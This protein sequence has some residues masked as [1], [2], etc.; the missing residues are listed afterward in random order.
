[1]IIGLF[2]NK[3][4]IDNLKTWPGYRKIP[5]RLNITDEVLND[6]KLE[7]LGNKTAFV[8]EGEKLSYQLLKKKVN[9]LII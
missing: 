9:G 8:F 5:D 1:M 6:Q 4:K 3:M 2:Q 7:K